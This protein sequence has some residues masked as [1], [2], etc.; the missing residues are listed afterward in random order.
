LTPFEKLGLSAPSLKAI[1]ELGFEQPTLIQRQAIPQLITGDRDFIGLAQTGTGKTAAFGLPLI[2]QE[3]PHTKSI[4]ALILAPTRELGKQI[5]DQLALFSK[6][7]QH[8]N[9]L[10]VYG[11]APIHQQIRELR[12]PPQILIATPGRL[13]DLI[14]R[15][16]VRLDKIRFLILDEA[17]EMLNMGF[18]EE[19]DE[20]LTHTPSEKCTWLFSATMAAPIRQMVK[21]YMDNPLEVKIAAQSQVNQNIEHLFVTV[22]REDKLEALIRF[23]DLTPEMRGVVFCRTRHETQQ[24]AEDLLRRNFKTDALHGDI[25]QP[26]R[27]RVMRRFKSHALQVLIATDVAARGIDINDLSH[28]FHYTLPDEK[29]YYTHRSG[30]TAR[31]GK[32]GTSIAFVNGREVYRIKH[33]E[34]DLNIRFEKTRIPSVA[35]IHASRAEARC[36]AVL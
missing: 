13:I 3:D 32:A 5:A 33:L 34:S 15:K 14:G 23:L 35:D 20:I 18:K 36:L 26:Q 21:Q 4:Q 24:L 6:Y 19:L 27:E 31:A 29:A 9:V 28:V 1:A 8:L 2:E 12:R 30:R 11:G 25:S 17:D 22:R 16:A 7:Q 10:A